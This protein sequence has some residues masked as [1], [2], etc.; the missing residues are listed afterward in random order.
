MSVSGTQAI[1]DSGRPLSTNLTGAPVLPPE[2]E[3]GLIINISD[4]VPTIKQHRRAQAVQ[5]GSITWR[6]RAQHINLAVSIL[7]KRGQ[8]TDTIY[9]QSHLAPLCMNFLCLLCSVSWYCSRR[10]S[11]CK[12]QRQCTCAVSASQNSTISHIRTQNTDEARHHQQA[13]ATAR[14]TQLLTN[15]P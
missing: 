8:T 15:H 13:H 2:A 14:A 11:L 9:A 5:G 4:L 10:V 7:D 1:R 12:R 6:S 3:R